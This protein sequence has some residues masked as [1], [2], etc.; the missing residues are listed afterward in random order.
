MMAKKIPVHDLFAAI[1][2]YF[3]V[4]KASTPNMVSMDSMVESF[5]GERKNPDVTA[6]DY[7]GDPFSLV[8]TYKSVSRTIDHYDE[9]VT[10]SYQIPQICLEGEDIKAINQ[11]ILDE[12][13]DDADSIENASDENDGITRYKT[14]DYHVYSQN[15][16]LSL[17]IDGN[18]WG[19]TDSPDNRLIYTISI[20]SEKRISNLC[21]LNSYGVDC[22]KV[23]NA[24]AKRIKADY[25]PIKND[26]EN[27]VNNPESGFDEHIYDDLYNSTMGR[28]SLVGEYNQMF[29]DDEGNL[30]ILYLYK[31]IAGSDCYQ[32][33]MTICSSD[34][35]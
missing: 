9:K 27:W 7:Y 11:E 22:Q 6:V 3:D 24:F 19:G 17:V 35:E 2:G 13:V 32:K 25:D 10:I 26:P 16:V 30:N 4:E 21:L 28:F 15:G 1:K 12:F 23:A 14:V 8:S 34:L 29:F 18:G 5:K 33:T 20:S 31:W